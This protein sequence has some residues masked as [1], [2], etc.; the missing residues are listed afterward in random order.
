MLD[1]T[2]L[3]AWKKE[4]VPMEVVAVVSED[5]T[6]AGTA[7]PAAASATEQPGRARSSSS[8]SCCSSEVDLRTLSASQTTR[9]FKAKKRKESRERTNELIGRANCTAFA[10]EDS[11]TAPRRMEHLA[12]RARRQATCRPACVR[13]VAV[14]IASAEADS[15]RA[16]A[17]LLARAA[18]ASESHVRSRPQRSRVAGGASAANSTAGAV[19]ALLG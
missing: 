1:S 6:P 13:A 8:S 9:S 5:C 17:S 18:A 4:K 2:G 15:D 12:S 16:G 7:L 3:P 19:R 11:A 14:H 10:D